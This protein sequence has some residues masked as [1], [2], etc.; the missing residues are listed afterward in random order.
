M[1]VS[2]IF[3]AKGGNVH[4]RIRGNNL[5]TR[6]VF[7]EGSIVIPNKAA[8][9]DNEAWLKVVKVVSPDIRKMKV[10]T[11]VCVLPAEVHLLLLYF[12]L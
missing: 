6:Y 5:V 11:V 2:V 4:P 10:S 8:Y 7:P 3:L 9:M 1:N 12:D